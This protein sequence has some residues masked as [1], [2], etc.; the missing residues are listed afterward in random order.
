MTQP[1]DRPR[2]ADRCDRMLAE[3]PHR[4]SHT[5]DALLVFLVIDRIAQLAHLCQVS[6]KIEHVG[7][8][9]A[10]E[11][12]ESMLLHSGFD[13]GLGQI[14]HDG[15]AHG[16]AIRG[17]AASHTRRQANTARWFNLFEI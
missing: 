7:D 12:S 17:V 13:L 6:T 4:S 3:T 11:L 16:G 9:L 15:F 14:S 1:K 8:G 10:R 2:D 5:K